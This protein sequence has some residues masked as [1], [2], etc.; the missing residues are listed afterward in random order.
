MHYRFLM[1]PV[2]DAQHAELVII[3]DH[4][5][6]FGIHFDGVLRYL[7]RARTRLLQLH[8]DGFRFSPGKIL[9]GVRQALRVSHI[10]GLAAFVSGLPIGER[11]LG[12]VSREPHRHVGGMRMHRKLAVCRLVEVKHAD[13]IVFIEHFHLVRR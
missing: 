5:V 3:E 9:I 2:L 6:V 10:I 8:H 1:R 4:F 12:M 13:S 7:R 11:V